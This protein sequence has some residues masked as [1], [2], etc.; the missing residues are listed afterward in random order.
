MKSRSINMITR[1]LM[2]LKS[3]RYKKV[4][5]QTMK[6]ILQNNPINDSLFNKEIERK[7]RTKWN[8]LCKNPSLDCFKVY[9]SIHNKVDYNFVSHYLYSY[10]MKGVLSD[11]RYNA[12]YT[13]KN[14]YEKRL[15]QYMHLFPNALFRKINGVYLDKDYNYIS[16]IS[17]FIRKLPNIEVLTKETTQSAGGKGVMIFKKEKNEGHFIAKSNY[18]LNHFINEQNNFVVQE[19]LKQSNE[20]ARLNATSIN[21]VRVVTY[22]S[23][24]NNQVHVVHSLV[25]KGDK[26]SFLDNWH[27]G[28]S[29]ITIYNSGQISN[30]GYNYNFEKVY[31]NVTD[32]KIPKLNIMYELA[33]EISK[34]EYYHRVLSF[35]FCLDNDDNVRIIEINYGLSSFFQITCGSL[36]GEY[37]DEIID[38]CK[39]NIGYI[40]FNAPYF[41]RNYK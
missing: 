6:R 5:S 37:T 15:P 38:Y 7:Y 20:M 26:N 14:L 11:E 36:F 33:M 28:G 8:P 10:L 21:T 17:T 16:D 4:Y 19:K 40:S 41:S 18:T 1:I 29:I 2:K 9:S 39:H 23:V 25:R 3:A 34:E 22:R 13:D 31:H 32:F 30:F 12:Y 35:D 24:V 27:S